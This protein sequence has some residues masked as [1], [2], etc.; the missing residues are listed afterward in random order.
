MSDWELANDQPAESD[1]ALSEPEFSLD[2]YRKEAGVEQFKKYAGIGNDPTGNTLRNIASGLGTAGQNIASTFTGGQAPTVNM[3]ETFGVTDETSQPLT[4]GIAQYSPLLATGGLGSAAANIGAAGAYGATQNPESP[5]KG[6][7]MDAALGSLPYAGKLG[8]K[9]AKSVIG[10]LKTADPVKLI[11]SI[12]KAHDTDMQASSS[13]YEAVKDSAKSR[14][15]NRIPIDESIIEQATQHF[16]KTLRAQNLIKKAKTGDYEALH[17]LQSE[18]GRKGSKWLSSPDMANA[19][20][21]E[22]ML[23]AR[24]ALNTQLEDFFDKTGNY[25][26]GDMLRSGRAG[27]KKLKD[28]Y[29]DYNPIKNMVHPDLK[30]IPK[31]PWNILTE[32]SVPVKEMLAEHPEIAKEIDK[33]LIK[34][35]FKKG[36]IGAG[37]IGGAGL[38]YKTLKDFIR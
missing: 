21:G 8:Y 14:G 11:K 15:I 26:L 2:K 12:Q 38:G 29:Y 35:K 17:D 6:A 34:Q 30:K 31:E 27:W 10:K 4:K 16:P 9:A 33:Y 1:W 5:L 28:T 23:E 25:D 3:D 7:A 32:H 13:L 24:D 18:I 19:N 36:I 22:E 37:L 20:A